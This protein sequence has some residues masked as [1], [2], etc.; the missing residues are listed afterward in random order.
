MQKKISTNTVE[1]HIDNETGKATQ[2]KKTQTYKVP[3]EPPYIK[4]Y[5]EDIQRF[6]DLPVSS[7]PMIYELLR[8]LDYD[9]LIS[10]NSTNKKIMCQKLGWTIGSLDNYLTKLKKCELFRSVGKGVLQPD[11]RIFGRGSWANIFERREAWIKVSH[12]KEGR[13]IQTSFSEE[14]SIKD[15]SEL[16]E[17][18][19]EKGVASGILKDIDTNKEVAEEESL[20]GEFNEERFK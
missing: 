19:Q 18:N 3:Q 1:T 4:M 17:I 13:E 11:P 15:V 9:G 12:T 20:E 16:E 5:I 6:Y 7:S 2:T 10:L 8:K 14:E